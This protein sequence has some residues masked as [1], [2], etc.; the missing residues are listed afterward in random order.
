MKHRKSEFLGPQRQVLAELWVV[1]GAS[2]LAA[3]FRAQRGPTDSARGEEAS[4]GPKITM[5]WITLWAVTICLELFSL[6]KIAPKSEQSGGCDPLMIGLWVI[7][8]C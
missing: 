1:T 7:L 6:K 3:R 5:G 2:L 4:V 8:S